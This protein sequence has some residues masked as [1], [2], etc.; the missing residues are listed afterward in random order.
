MVAVQPEAE[1]GEMFDEA[2]GAGKGRVG[3]I[4]VARASGRNV[5]VPL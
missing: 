4:A 5:W 2:A 3:Q 1:L